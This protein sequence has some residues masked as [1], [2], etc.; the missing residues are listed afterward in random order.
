[1]QRKCVCREYKEM[2]REGRDGKGEGKGG[3]KEKRREKGREFCLFF[4]HLLPFQGVL[5]YR[6]MTIRENM[7]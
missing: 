4:N 6:T 7:I 1:M 2:I 5:M 3:I